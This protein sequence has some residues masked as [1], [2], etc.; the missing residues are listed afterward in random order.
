MNNIRTQAIDAYTQN[1]SINYYNK[2][3]TIKKIPN[4]IIYS[5][6]LYVKLLLTSYESNYYKSDYIKQSTFIIDNFYFS[7]NLSDKNNTRFYIDNLL[8]VKVKIFEDDNNIFVYVANNEKFYGNH[9]KVQEIESFGDTLRLTYHPYAK[10][11]ELP[12]GLNEIPLKINCTDNSVYRVMDSGST[13]WQKA[14]KIATI[15]VSSIVSSGK[16]HFSFRFTLNSNSQNGMYRSDFLIYYSSMND[17]LRIVNLA[18]DSQFK[19]IYYKTNKTDDTF[20]IDLYT[21]CCGSGAS[22]EMRILQCE[23]LNSDNLTIYKNSEYVL[24]SDL[25]LT[26]SI[27]TDVNFNNITCNGI[28]QLPRYSTL[29]SNA[30]KDSIVIDGANGKPAWF[31]GSQW[32]HL[33]I[34]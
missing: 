3:L 25:D 22:C 7:N 11:E 9:V 13:D 5:M 30:P 23:N 10:C 8:N 6:R 4:N 21:R 15:K 14:F 31:N 12:E 19:S 16:N 29:P 33:S 32:K 20:S 1:D 26:E 28:L 24:P 27:K 34:E 2:I 18:V 17:N